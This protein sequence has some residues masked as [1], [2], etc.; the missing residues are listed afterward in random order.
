MPAYRITN[1]FN[2]QNYIIRYRSDLVPI[3]KKLSLTYRT[4]NNDVM[5]TAR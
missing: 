2:L 1:R 4:A 5:P 3:H